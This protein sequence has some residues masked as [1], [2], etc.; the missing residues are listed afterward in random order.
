M[1]LTKIYIKNFRLILDASID[2]DKEL[3]LIVGKNNSGKTSCLHFIKKIFNE[4]KF[5]YDD[6]PVI[7][8]KRLFD[9]VISYFQGKLSFEELREKFEEPSIRFFCRLFRR[10]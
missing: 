3:T 6:Y 4:E 5:Y 10:T 1:Y 2:F 8:R 7:K 9:S